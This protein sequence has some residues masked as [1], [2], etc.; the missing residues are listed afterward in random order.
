MPPRPKKTPAQLDAEI[1]TAL[2]LTE[3]PIAKAEFFTRPS[4]DAA[5]RQKAVHQAL[6]TWPAFVVTD[7]RGKRTLLIH[8]GEMSNPEEGAHRVTMFGADGPVGH[9]ARRSL[10]RLAQ[11]LSRDLWPARIT[12]ADDLQVMEWMSTPE[13]AE[14]AERALEMQ[15]RNAR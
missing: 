8:S 2:A 6:L 12:P 5:R 7:R 10:T 15:R 4:Q 1:A 11:D 13:Y 14:G 3:R 9:I